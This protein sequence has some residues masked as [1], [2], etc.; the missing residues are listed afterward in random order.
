MNNGSAV[1]TMPNGAGNASPQTGVQIGISRIYS[2]NHR[3]EIKG[4]P[5][6]VEPSDWKPVIDF[7]ANPRYSQISPQQVEVVLAIQLDIKQSEDLIVQ[8][9]WEQAGLFTFSNLSAEQLEMVAYGACPNMLFP[10]ACVMVN[11]ML[12][13]NGL[14]PVYLAPMDFVA[15]YRQ[16][17]VQQLEQKEKAA[18]PQ[19]VVSQ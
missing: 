18:V 17:L 9:Y 2:K 12:A 19:P 7:K 13:S 3:L 15:L 11:Q 5:T 1:E 4:L 14:P 8:I 10:Y 6:A 16:H